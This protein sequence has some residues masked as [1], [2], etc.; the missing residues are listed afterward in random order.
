MPNDPQMPPR[1]RTRSK[2]TNLEAG[3]GVAALLVVLYHCWIHC[4]E[5]YGDFG[6]GHLVAF[7]HAGVDFFFVLSGFII[8]EA[9]RDD[10]G[11]SKRLSHYIERRVTRIYP[12]YWI[13]L[14]LTL[15]AASMSSKAFPT[16]YHIVTSFFLVPT[17]Q[18]PVMVDA[19]TLQH[20]M[21]FYTVFALIILNRRL[22]IA[23]FA[24][25]LALIVVARLVPIQSDS[26]FLLKLSSSFNFEFFLGMG[27][28][29]FGRW[30][31]APAPVLFVIA[32][33]AAFLALGAAEDAALV[34]NSSLLLHLGYGTAA[35]LA[36]IGLVA[37]E[38]DYGLAAPRPMVVLGG[39]S[40]SLYLVHVL[41]IGAIWQ[42]VLKFRLEG[43]V[44][45]WVVYSVLIVGAVVTGV[46]FNYLVEKP[47]IAFARRVLTRRPAAIA[48][49]AG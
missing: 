37:L 8:F 25:W 16:A 27:A 10:I 1:V 7:G 47:A 44:P 36:V 11:N 33:V 42:I 48:S 46:V 5:A 14:A 23:V 26:G 9:H 49:I 6:L 29:W 3:R 17:R 4:R 28:A 18:D 34:A 22:G 39:A 20:E 12:V 43:A 30:W 32:G 19:W 38:R 31:K 24:L 2:L 45:V 13:I 41:A 21:L 40:Y 35:M 15:L